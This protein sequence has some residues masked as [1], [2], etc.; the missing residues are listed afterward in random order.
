MSFMRGGDQV[1]PVHHMT[2]VLES[3]VLVPSPGIPLARRTPQTS[4][5]KRGPW[6][7]VLYPLH[8]LFFWGPVRCALVQL[9]PRNLSSSH[10][11]SEIRDSPGQSPREGPKCAGRTV[12][13][14]G[15]GV[16]TRWDLVNFTAGHH[17]GGYQTRKDECL[18]TNHW[19]GSINVNPG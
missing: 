14:L 10:P 2:W 6:M 5:P 17:L 8:G 19:G 13:M 7:K 9:Q 18:F 4:R 11:S 15:V 3:E 12:R 1:A 16:R